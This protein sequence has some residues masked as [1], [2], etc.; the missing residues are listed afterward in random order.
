M[1]AKYDVQHS[2]VENILGWIRDKQIAIPEIQRPFVWKASKVRDLIDS[3]YKGYP[4]GYLI[5][6]LN[7]DVKLK[8]GSI[9]AGKKILI[10][11]QQRITALTAAIVGQRVLD[12]NYKQKFIRIS[13]NPIEEKFE[14]QNASIIRN[15][16]WL[17]SIHEILNG[18]KSIYSVIKE[19]KETN[20]K[21]PEELIAQRLSRLEK[22]KNQQIGIISLHSNLSIDVVTEIFIRI[23]AEGVPLS[24][25]DF[26]MSKISADEAYGG[27]IMRKSIDYFC[28]LIQDRGF[29][30]HIEDN[31]EE[32]TGDSLFNE[33]KWIASS[34]DDLY[35][36]EYTDVLRVVFTH[37]FLRGR[38]SDLVALL[39]GRN[40]ETRENEEEIAERSFMKLR[41]GLS[42]FFS[43]TNYQRFLMIIAS[44]GFV[45][46]KLISSQNSL[47]FAYV[48][49]LFL[50]EQNY[51]EPEKEKYVKKWLVMSLLTGR[52]SGSSES[53]IDEDIK[54]IHENGIETA[55]EHM[56]KSNLGEGFWDYG[57]PDILETSSTRNNAYITYLAA[58]CYSNSHAFLSNSMTIKSLIE[59]R[60]DVHHIFPKA[61]LQKAGFSRRHYNQIGNYVYTLQNT[62]IKIGKAAP[63]DYFNRVK[64][65]INT[66]VHE[67]TSLESEEELRRNLKE[68][69]I[70]SWVS[71]GDHDSFLKFLEERRHLMALKIK[72]YYEQL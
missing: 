64:E 49:Y 37:K 22:I 29:I 34:T 8:D 13:F 16:L 27:N 62:N 4:V 69:D 54:Q 12:K 3:L 1:S 71:T 55:L 66:K 26:I 68:N 39:S 46:G 14:V 51:T 52:Y 32:F 17:D 31:D 67:L 48:I 21:F 72:K 58:Q 2:T 19:Y 59:Q 61:Y 35:Q 41:E 20:P 36:P 24:S 9:S 25:A 18:E 47:N 23:N 44:A 30:K 70:P 43:K 63:Q 5:T 40:F 53:K 28:R 45:D 7:S 50:T 6:W 33:I 57:L 56:E 11:G 65:E 10:D 60:G 15:P 38:F 42:T